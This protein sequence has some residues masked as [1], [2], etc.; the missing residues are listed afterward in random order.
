MSVLSVSIR[1]SDSAR[2]LGVVVDSRLSMA[3][4]FDQ[5]WPDDT[6]DLLGR[7]YR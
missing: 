7:S 1:V 2:I 3:D 6:V 5:I 4:D